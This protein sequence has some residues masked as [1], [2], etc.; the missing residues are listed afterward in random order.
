MVGANLEPEWSMHPNVPANGRWPYQ[1]TGGAREPHAAA[2]DSSVIAG[3]SPSPHQSEPPPKWDLLLILVAGLLLVSQARVHVFIP[4]V[5]ALRPGLLLGVLAMGIWLTRKEAIRALRSLKIPMVKATVFLAAWAAIGVPFALW[6][7]GAAYFL[8]ESFSR[9]LL[10]FGLIAAAVRSV[11]DV[12][13]LV[14]AAA[15]GAALFAFMAARG[16]Q[17]RS[18]AAGGYDPNDSAMLMVSSIPLLLYFTLFGR[19]LI[20]RGAAGGGTL[21][22]LFGVIQ[23]QSR[24]GFV[25]LVVVLGF[26]V[27]MLRGVKPALRAAVVVV[28]VLASI[29]VATSEFWERMETIAEF[30]DGYG[31]AG[32]GG[33]RNIW[34]R[35]IGYTASNPLTGV[36]IANF[37]VA[38]GRHPAIRARIAAGQ[39]TKYSA[40]HSMWF[41]ALAE[42][43]LPGFIAFV[44]V[45]IS[46]LFGLRR[47]QRGRAPPPPH[48]KAKEFQALSS[49]LMASIVGS[50]AAGAFLSNAYSGLIWCTLG[51]A[52]GLLKVTSKSSPNGRTPGSRKVRQHG[53]PQPGLVGASAVDRTAPAMGRRISP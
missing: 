23:T 38:E 35:A 1:A 41:Q 3:G 22:A 46:A 30:D 12:R 2:G 14:G 40:A 16:A 28:V 11:E 39:G 10:V 51:I 43:G 9:T 17:G 42:L 6:Q 21:L 34:A 7:G 44:M 53:L 20:T 37:E 27:L 52:A 8:L 32:I 31:E 45:F 5:S 36:G 25:A 15:G 13:R 48:M 19:S 4:G 24:G 49:I 29:P 47:I 33:R 18:V 26:M 50:M